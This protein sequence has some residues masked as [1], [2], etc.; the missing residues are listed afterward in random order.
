MRQAKRGSSKARP[1]SDKA[2]DALYDAIVSCELAP[3]T[4][5]KASEISEFLEVGRTPTVR[6]LMRLE[7]AGFTR[8]AKRK[9]WQVTPVTLQGVHDIIDVFRVLA[10]GLAVLIIRNASD[11]QI[12]ALREMTYRWAPADPE[13]ERPSDFG[14][15]PIRYYVDI[16]GNPMMA[17]MARGAA[18][19][20]ERV[21]NFGLRHGE[22]I[23]SRFA[24]W[25]DIHLDALTNRDEKRA[26]DSMQKLIDVEESE[27]NR[28]LQGTRSIR[29]IPIRAERASCGAAATGDRVACA[30]DDGW[31]GGQH[32]GDSGRVYRPRWNTSASAVAEASRSAT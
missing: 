12:D 28:I 10:P 15:G 31:H 2:F 22:F 25:R 17:E 1:M 9:G 6:A 19:H 30:R 16:C 13:S 32:R 3:G 8:P 7:E 11:H 20:H 26:R 4:W 23:D 14:F 21:V 29:S 27:L 5:M 24:R 18:A